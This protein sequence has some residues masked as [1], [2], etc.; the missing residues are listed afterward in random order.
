MQYNNQWMVLDH[1]KF[2][3]GQP[4]ANDTLWVLEQLPGFTKAHDLTYEL[5]KQGY[6]ASYNVP[7]FA[8]IA[9]MA[10]VSRQCYRGTL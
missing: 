9:E 4:L 5:T 2:T 1:T 7:F 6:W 10:G 3:P 8:T